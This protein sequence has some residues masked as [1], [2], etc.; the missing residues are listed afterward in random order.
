VLGRPEVA[1]LPDV[2]HYGDAVKAD[3]FGEASYLAEL[4][5][6]LGRPT[7]PGKIAYVEI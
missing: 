2:V 5:G 3:V 1:D 7:R 6:E 4:G